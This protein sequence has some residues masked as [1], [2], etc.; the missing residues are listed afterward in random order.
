MH[1]QYAVLCDQVILAN[2]G[3]PSLIGILNDRPFGP[4]FN[5]RVD[6]EKIDHALQAVVAVP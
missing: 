3:K 5:T 1:L 2:D 6:V 4:C